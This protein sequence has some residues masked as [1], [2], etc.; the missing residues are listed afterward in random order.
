MDRKAVRHCVGTLIGNSTLL[1]ASSCLTRSLR[2]PGADCGR[3]IHAIFPESNGHK[4][5][6]TSCKRILSSDHSFFDDPALRRS[7]I[8]RIQLDTRSSREIS[9]GLKKRKTRYSRKG[10]EEGEFFQAWKVDKISDFEAVVKKE[11]CKALYRSYANPF[12][13]SKNSAFMTLSGCSFEEG[14]LGSAIMDGNQN[15]RGLMSSALSKSMLSFL[16]SRDLLAET[17]S[18]TVHVS[19][20]ACAFRS[21]KDSGSSKRLKYTCTHVKTEKELKRL[22]FEMLRDKRVHRRNKDQIEKDLEKYKK[23]FKW[24]I[25]F[26]LNPSRNI[27]ETSIEQPKCF[28]ESSKWL[29][30]FRSRRR[31]KERVTQKIN[32]KNYR[33]QIMLNS[34]LKPVSVKSETPDKNYFISFSPR[35]IFNKKRTWVNIRTQVFG[36]EESHYYNR[37]TGVCN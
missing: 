36:K 2:I 30:E 33:L 17:P 10:F 13:T 25:E 37:V 7:D 20:L 32:L 28:H 21:F 1:V 12:V 26:F 9:N 35:D 3:T 34:S 19:N 5:I 23:Y 31:Y 8:A 16:E 29:G 15:V 22:R 24:D 27:L 18:E 4:K 11:T 6:V 14:N